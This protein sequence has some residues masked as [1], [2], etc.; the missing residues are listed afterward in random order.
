MPR[1]RN[2]TVTILALG[3]AL[4]S[5]PY[6]AGQERPSLDVPFVPTPEQVVET[7]LE[8]AKVT[9]D[10]VL[11]DLG[12]GDGRIVITAAKKYGIRGVGYD[13]D[14]ERVKEARDNARAA[15]VA[16]RVR[17][18]VQNVFD[19][20]FR[21]ATVVT[22]Y[23]LPAVNLKLRPRILGELRPG[24]RVVSHDFDMG[25]WTPEKTVTVTGAGGREHTV[26]LWVVPPR[27]GGS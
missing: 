18:E 10:D 12:S 14:P 2:A 8:V 27:K 1:R 9:K 6:T 16:D 20:D 15:G 22:M 13:L 3:L 23:L 17:F 4:L 26:Y 19:A 21:E 24:T 5:A 11:Y 7:M 25:D